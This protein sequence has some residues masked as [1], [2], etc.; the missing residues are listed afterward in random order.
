LTTDGWVVLIWNGRQTETS[1]FLRE[2]EE[3][4]QKYG[5]DYKQVNHR[6]IDIEAITAF[7]AP[8]SFTRREFASQQVF[9]LEG[10]TG[11]LLSSSYAPEPGHPNHQ[12]MLNTLRALF[13]RH[14]A[15]D[16]VTLDYTTTM[17]FG[18]LC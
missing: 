1:P 12:A 7:F 11:R 13:D 6:N 5:T 2:Y 15:H 16:K 14:R 4:L 18:H 3:L 9:D 17:Y 8:Q 10:L